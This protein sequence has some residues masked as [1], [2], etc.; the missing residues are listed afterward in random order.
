M[1]EEVAAINQDIQ[2]LHYCH[3]I[4]I[5]D[6]LNPTNENIVEETDL[7]NKEIL[8]IVR[9]LEMNIVRIIKRVRKKKFMCF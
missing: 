7:T 8:E 5:K 2:L 3:S 9:S 1:K 6:F 4:A